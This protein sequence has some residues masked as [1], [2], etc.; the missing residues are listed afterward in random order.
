M[1]VYFIAALE[2]DRVKIGYSLNPKARLVDLQMG[3]PVELT[4]LKS[5][6]GGAAEERS[7]HE[8]FSAHRTR[9]E[10]FK[11]SSIASEIDALPLADHRRPIAPCTQCGEMRY[12]AGCFAKKFSETGLCRKCVRPFIGNKRATKGQCVICGVTT[13]RKYAK[14]QK[15]HVFVCCDAHHYA[16]KRAKKALAAKKMSAIARTL[17][18]NGQW[19]GRGGPQRV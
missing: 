8:R 19:H 2:L 4:L 17:A 16:H 14:H 11:L 18:A 1:P 12:R 9:G 13:S 10:W 6:P 7:L 15:P 5:T 3:A